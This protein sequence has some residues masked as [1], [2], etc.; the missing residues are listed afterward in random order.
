[1]D[2][3]R[4]RPSLPLVHHSMLPDQIMN[5]LTSRS[6]IQGQPSGSALCWSRICRFVPQHSYRC[7]PGVYVLAPFNLSFCEDIRF[8]LLEGF[9]TS[10]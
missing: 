1:M 5:V 10:E 6:G 8:A 4:T 9:E 2:S 3:Q 7:W